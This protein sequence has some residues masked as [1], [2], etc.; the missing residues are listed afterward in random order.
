VTKIQLMQR[1]LEIQNITIK[2][3][4]RDKERLEKLCGDLWEFVPHWA[5]CEK[6]FIDEETY[7]KLE[8]QVKL[9]G[10]K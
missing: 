6:G 4:W 9:E 5:D 8:R 3:L 1:S 7:D 10:I 2:S